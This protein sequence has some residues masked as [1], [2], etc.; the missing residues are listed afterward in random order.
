MYLGP[1]YLVKYHHVLAPELTTH[2][3]LTPP[4]IDSEIRSILDKPVP[5]TIHPLI[6]FSCQPIPTYSRVVT[7]V[8]PCGEL[9]KKR[10]ALKPS[11]AGP[12]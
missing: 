3:S 11:P 12:A 2:T 4:S 8:P 10:T 9:E 1:S 7:T 5:R 6:F